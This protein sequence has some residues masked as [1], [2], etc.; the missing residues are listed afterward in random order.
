MR[1]TEGPAVPLFPVRLA[2]S[3]SGPRGRAPARPASSPRPPG[4]VRRFVLRIVIVI[5][6]VAIAIA[7]IIVTGIVVVFLVSIVV[8]VLGLVIPVRFVIRLTGRIVLG[9]V[10][11]ALVGRTILIIIAATRLTGPVVAPV[12]TIGVIGPVIVWPLIIRIVGLPVGPG[13]VVRPSSPPPAVRSAPPPALRRVVGLIVIVIVVR[14]IIGVIQPP[15]RIVRRADAGVDMVAVSLPHSPKLLG[16]CG[17]RQH[18]GRTLPGGLD[19]GDKLPAVRAGQVNI[20]HPRVPGR[21]NH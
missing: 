10:T 13:S 8:I 11:R 21:Q 17:A 18:L 12:V 14:I 2:S 7:V 6:T 9:T 15:A 19:P 4:V 1:R 16:R 3:S 20:W 5:V